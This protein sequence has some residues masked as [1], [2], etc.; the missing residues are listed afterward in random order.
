M[1][2]RRKKKRQHERRRA[3]LAATVAPSTAAAATTEAES[4]SQP[5]L[6]AVGEPKA[7]PPVSSSD[8]QFM[9]RDLMR[10]MIVVSVVIAVLVVMVISNHT[11]SWLDQIATQ[12]YHWLKLG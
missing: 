8:A 6:P 10:V 3:E 5:P 12:L 7:A 9:R 2:Q 1:S 11:N 4:L